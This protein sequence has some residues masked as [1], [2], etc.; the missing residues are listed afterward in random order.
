MLSA[1]FYNDSLQGIQVT[2]IMLF[3]SRELT[4]GRTI[5]WRKQ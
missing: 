2:T 1:K 4:C 3:I 5:A